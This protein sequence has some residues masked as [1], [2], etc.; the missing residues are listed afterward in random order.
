MTL[1]EL[2]ALLEQKGFRKDA[3]CIGPGWERLGDAF[4][5]D[6]VDGKF[7]WFFVERGLRGKADISFDSEDEAC[8]FAYKALSADKWAQ[9]HLVGFFKNQVDAEEFAGQLREKGIESNFD[10]IPYGG[11]QDPRFRVIVFGTDVFRVEPRIEE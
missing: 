11:P 10:R 1:S 7:E 5:L 4:A 2:A 3:Y 6:L 8:Q 9:S